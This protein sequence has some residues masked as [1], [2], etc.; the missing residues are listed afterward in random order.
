V[1]ARFIAGM[2]SEM[3]NKIRKPI[4]LSN[5][6]DGIVLECYSGKPTTTR[7]LARAD[8][9]LR[10]ETAE[11]G[12]SRLQ[13]AAASIVLRSVRRELPQW[14]AV[15]DGQMVVGR[16]VSVTGVRG[17]GAGTP[18]WRGIR[19]RSRPQAGRQSRFTRD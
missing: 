9:A 13:A 7:E 1:P 16:A 6:P 11:S 19:T 10:V 12:F 15:V 5:S 4:A 3:T 2:R 14:A 18:T 17:G 8:R